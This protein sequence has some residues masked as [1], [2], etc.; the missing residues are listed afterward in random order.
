M[1]NLTY[2]IKNA[3]IRLFNNAE[4]TH[5]FNTNGIVEGASTRKADSELEQNFSN[6]NS[7]VET[8]MSR[9]TRGKND[10]EV[11]WPCS[12]MILFAHEQPI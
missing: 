10:P 7:V 5:E 11:C 12:I 6:I 4:I 3:I 8:L 9:R 1:L 2:R